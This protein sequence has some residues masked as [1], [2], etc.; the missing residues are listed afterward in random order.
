MSDS[1]STCSRC[2]KPVHAV[3]L[4]RMHYDRWRR[5]GSPGPAGMIGHRAPL[6]ER[7]VNNVLI[8]GPIP[9]SQPWLGA[10]SLWMGYQHVSGFGAI[11]HSHSLIYVHRY[12]WEQVYGPAPG[13]IIDQICDNKLCVRVD[14]LE[15]RPSRRHP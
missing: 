12:A 14:H 4:C 15:L 9:S 1:A 7:F 2:S 10:C 3:G 6:E 5:Y 8:A 13:R 11:W